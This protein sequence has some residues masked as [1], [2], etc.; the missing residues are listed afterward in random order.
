[1]TGCPSPA[2]LEALA[3]GTCADGTARLHIDGCALCRAAVEEAR[4]NN[5]FLAGVRP[6]LAAQAGAGGAPS[7]RVPS[8]VEPDLVSGYHIQEEIHRGGQGVVYRAVQTR[9]HRTVAIK[10]LLGGRD[11]TERQKERFEREIRIAAGLRHPN[12]VT[13]HE[14]GFISDGQYGLVME[15]IEGVPL[16]RWSRSLDGARGHSAQRRDLRERLRVM[17]KVCDAV[18]CAHQHSILHRDLKPANILV[19]A[20]GEPHVLDFGIARDAGPGQPARMTH[21]GEFAGT[22]TYASPEQVS[23]DL[24]RVDTRTDIYSLGV[25]MYELVSG[26]MPYA[27][28]G[29]ISRAIR[30]IETAEPVPLPQRTRDP[31]GP[32]VDGEVS[33]IILKAMAKDPARRYQTVAG[34]RNDIARYLAGEAIEARRDSTWYVLRKT[35]ARHRVVVAAAGLIILLLAAFGA[36]MAWQARRLDVRGRDLASALS[37]SNVERGRAL[38]AAGDIPL[39]EAALWPELT[40]AGVT[41]IDGPEAGFDGS[42]EALHTYWALWDVFQESR[43]VAT[44]GSSGG[45]V[46]NLYFDEGGDRLCALVGNDNLISWST[47]TW[48]PVPE[49]GLVAPIDGVRFQYARAS[50]GAIAVLGGGAIRIIDPETGTLVAEADDPDH[51]A[52]TGAFNPDGSLLATIGRDNRLCIWDAHSLSSVTTIAE[53]VVCGAG[54]YSCWP[55]FSLDGGLVAAHRPDGSLGLWD[56]AYGILA[57]TLWPPGSLVEKASRNRDLSRSIAFGP[58]GAIAASLSRHIVVWPAD[59]KTAVVLGPAGGSVETVAFFPG[60]EGPML[61][62]S[63]SG[64]AGGTGV[65][66]FWNPTTGERGATFRHEFPASACAASPDSRLIAVGDVMGTVQVYDTASQPHVSTLQAR[67]GRIAL[68]PDGRLVAALTFDEKGFD[69]VLMDLESRTTINR[70][71]RNG[72]PIRDL[73][74]AR[75]SKFLFVSDATSGRVTQWDV[76]SGTPVREFLVPPADLPGPT[77]RATVEPG[78]HILAKLTRLSPDGSILA[79]AWE[80]GVIGLWDAPSARWIGWLDGGIADAAVIDFSPDGRTLVAQHSEE[81]VLW[82]VQTRQLKRVFARQRYYPAVCFSPNGETIAHNVGGGIEFMDPETGRVVGEETVPGSAGV[83]MVFHP[84]GSVLVAS[85]KEP[86][87]R[88]WDTRTGRELLSLQKHTGLIYTLLLTPDGNTLIS[89]DQSGTVLAWDLA[90]YNGHIRRELEHRMSH[91]SAP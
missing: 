21:T 40:R 27:V 54:R 17:I 11:A 58:D 47:A 3:A 1:M 10:M 46:E 83:A 51:Q 30:S 33:T 15:Y 79:R 19:D 72:P 73:E 20:S 56:T 65:T 90:Y 13:V 69:I 67:C 28:D 85:A 18:L 26:K 6:A 70:F 76:E 53:S 84:S 31:D 88:L 75:D 23:G 86:T 62:S 5:S 8:P 50:S 9:T 25:I 74:F 87:I 4:E 43:L 59:G 32:W 14:S 37:A 36:V 80:N 57:S 35:A 41:R 24:S 68:S 2:V 12:I 60:S 16:D 38:A 89:L 91:S 63:G 61:V 49:T 44:L 78:L 48:E 64:I 71:H 34:L 81:C 22:L 66:I 45:R 55:T 7:K 39:A 42:P 77:E 29:P 82:D 52:V